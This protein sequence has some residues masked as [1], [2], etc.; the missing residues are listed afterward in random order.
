MSL[1]IEGTHLA[2]ENPIGQTK[3]TIRIRESPS[4]VIAESIL[5]T[6]TGGE[7]FTEL[8]L[9]QLSYRKRVKPDKKYHVIVINENIGE[10][11]AEATEVEFT[12]DQ[13]R[14]INRRSFGG[15][16]NGTLSSLKS[17][18]SEE[19]ETGTS[20]AGGTTAPAAR[21]NRWRFPSRKVMIWLIVIVLA[22]PLL[23]YGGYRGFN[24][25][26]SGGVKK[27]FSSSHPSA[28][29]PPLPPDSADK[30]AEPDTEK[31]GAVASKTSE[32]PKAPKLSTV[33][34]PSITITGSNN[35]VITV[36]D[37]G[38]VNIYPPKSAE[39]ANAIST[40]IE[41][42]ILHDDVTSAPIPVPAKVT[43]K[44]EPEEKTSDS[45][46][47]VIS[48]PTDDWP[49]TPATRVIDIPSKYTEPMVRKI[50]IQLNKDELLYPGQVIQ[51]NRSPNWN[52]RWRADNS[53]LDITVDGKPVNATGRIAKGVADVT[54]EE[55]V[56]KFRLKPNINKPVPFKMWA[57][58]SW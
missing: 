9:A 13:A 2:I 48:V 47:N 52:F 16:E 1:N 54:G 53:Y 41:R 35:M 45:P 40:A 44:G 50:T 4:I 5:L 12:E 10:I 36:T 20:L 24:W 34:L 22:G 32:A 38:K 29:T 42:V 49:N 31:S 51:V 46:S 28:P 14:E 25:I 19:K 43:E 27:L 11:G 57:D 37:E 55:R 7:L 15:L 17:V 18:T 56:L 3:F 58:R 23:G 39:T 33:Q 21:R 6:K 8:D 30:K 26:K